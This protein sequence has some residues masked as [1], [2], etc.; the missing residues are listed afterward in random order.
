MKK[1]HVAIAFSLLFC[2]PL[3]AQQQQL[4]PEEAEKKRDEYIQNKIE[5]MESTLKLEDWQVFYVDSIFNHDY[6]A[7]TDEV[8][9]LKRDKVS[10]SDLYVAAQDKW[11]DRIDESLRKVLNDEQWEKYMKNGARKE[12]MAREKRKKKLAGGK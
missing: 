2:S 10:N 9:S 3:L 5:R 1:I 8:E 11:S 4:S 6:V 7:M 12:A